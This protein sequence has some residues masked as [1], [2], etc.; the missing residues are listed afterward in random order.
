MPCVKCPNGKW[1]LGSSKC[2]YSSKAACE[3]A[4]AAYRAKKGRTNGQNRKR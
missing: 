4:Y 2:M 3:R 1:R